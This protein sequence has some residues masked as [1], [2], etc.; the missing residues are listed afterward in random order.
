MESQQTLVRRMKLFRRGVICPTE[1]W[2]PLFENLTPDEVDAFLDGVD[3]ELQQ[4]ILD[5]Y[6]GL[7]SY[8]F[9]PIWIEQYAFAERDT[10]LAIKEWC[11]KRLA[12]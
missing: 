5:E 12:W 9:E 1:M 2:M 11:E 4:L 3:D 6:T 10:V 7:A 8:R